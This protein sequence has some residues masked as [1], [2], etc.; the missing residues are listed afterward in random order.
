L[1][2]FWLEKTCWI[3]AFAGMTMVSRVDLKSVS[4]PYERQPDMKQTSTTKILISDRDETPEI[5]QVDFD[6]A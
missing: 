6:R 4:F 3:P 5:T 1:Q 2:P